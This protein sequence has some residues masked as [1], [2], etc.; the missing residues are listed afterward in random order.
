MSFNTFSGPWSAGPLLCCSGMQE[1]K[2]LRLKVARAELGM[3]PGRRMLLPCT[4]FLSIGP[5]SQR[6][7]GTTA[8]KTRFQHFTGPQGR[9]SASSKDTSESLL[10]SLCSL[11]QGS[12]QLQYPPARLS[13]A[14]RWI[15]NG[16]KDPPRSLPLSI[17]LLRARN[18]QEQP[19]HNGWVTQVGVKSVP[20]YSVDR[21]LVQITV[22]PGTFREHS[23][24]NPGL[25]LLSMLFRVRERKI[26]LCLFSSYG[27]F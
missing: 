27:S 24:Q 4:A 15:G 3:H 1:I 17:H 14:G 20:Y 23:F 21:T 8:P 22:T 18:K 5:G 2:K 12:N 13:C 7:L 9:G 6:L 19:E 25:S 16:A 11:V 26:R 10:S